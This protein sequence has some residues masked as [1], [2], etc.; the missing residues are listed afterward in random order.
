M[1]PE[2]LKYL[3]DIDVTQPIQDRVE[4][5]Y[6]LCRDML[7]GKLLDI[8]IDDYLT[9]DKSRKYEGLTFCSKDYNFSVPNFL[10][11][12]KINIIP[13]QNVQDSIVITVANYDFKKTNEESLMSVQLYLKQTDAGTYKASR[14]N[15]A[16]LVRILR[17]YVEPSLRKRE[18]KISSGQ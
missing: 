10:T 17:R 16:Y 1:K 2:F 15:C 5:F 4:H 18:I 3:E 13:H 12:E 14:N 8:F 9:E 7:F 11:S 6:C